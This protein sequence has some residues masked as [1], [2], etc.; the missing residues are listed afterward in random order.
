MILIKNEKDCC[1]CAACSSVCPVQCITMVE[2]TLGHVFPKVDT[3]KCIGCNQCEM[4]CPILKP[5]KNTEDNQNIYAA[6][7]KNNEIRYNGSSGGMFGTFA[8]FLIEQGYKVYGAAFDENLTLK[9]TCV[10]N[11]SDLLPLMKSKYIQ[12][13]L[14][15]KYSEIKK[16]L[17]EGRKVLFVSTPCQ[18][19][20]L[21]N[22]L[23]KEYDN[24]VTIDFFCHGVPSQSFF[25]KCKKYVEEKHKIKVTGYI[26]R[27]KVKNGS[28][29]HYF[30]IK[31][32]E[33]DYEKS[34]T[35]LYFDS[36]FYAAFQKYI[37]LRESC[38]DCTFSSKERNSDITIADFHDIEKYINDIN[39]FEGVSTVITNTQK[40]KKVLDN[41]KD[42]LY[43]KE[44]NM[45][46]LIDD[47]VCFNGG[48][49]RPK[50]RDEF[51]DDYNKMNFDKFVEKWMNPKKYWKQRIYYSLPSVIRNNVKKILGVK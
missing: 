46:Q 21:K 37:C 20:A 10:D 15:N 51:I 26:F 38:Y 12:S 9:C 14:S 49:Q 3:K 30:T 44:M 47:K 23:K 24:L 33:N 43:I 4:V 7:S 39:R 2:G 32:I 25:D 22:Y 31:Y 42:S 11:K 36:P 1:G 34:K 8:T 27:T 17:Q 35:K 45:K 40:G 16:N 6:Y 13:D 5:A 28:T 29:P 19:S 18:V 50:N 48:T 41:C